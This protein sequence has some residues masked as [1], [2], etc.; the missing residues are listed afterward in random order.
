MPIRPSRCGC[1]VFSS[2]ED[3]PLPVCLRARGARSR[4]RAPLNVLSA[5]SW[6]PYLPSTITIAYIS[7]R[8]GSS[9][10]TRFAPDVPAARSQLPRSFPLVPLTRRLTSAR[11][12]THPLPSSRAWWN[13]LDPCTA[14]RAAVVAP[15]SRRWFH[16]AF[17]YRIRTRTFF[18]R[19]PSASAPHPSKRAGGMTGGPATPRGRYGV[20]P[21]W[22]AP[23]DPPTHMCMSAPP[24]R[25]ALTRSFYACVLSGCAGQGLPAHSQ[26]GI[27][28]TTTLSHARRGR[29]G[30]YLWT[31]GECRSRSLCARGKGARM[32]IRV[33]SGRKREGMVVRYHDVAG[34][35]R[36]G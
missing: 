7:R 29:G 8:A 1:P 17:Y 34:V 12:R 5:W 10:L 14:V 11:M 22:R 9:N 23:A 18:G 30:A 19:L 21:I 25:N 16:A 15:Y 24:I 35:R 26:G 3:R 2:N 6:L 31:Y 33:C 20:R 36:L 28:P 32:R 27:S 4:A 13:V